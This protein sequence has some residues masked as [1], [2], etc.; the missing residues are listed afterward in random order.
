MG[1]GA[2]DVQGLSKAGDSAAR[3]GA[4]TESL[5]HEKTYTPE[6]ARLQ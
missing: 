5:A 2:L 3:A 6:V 1:S 4:S